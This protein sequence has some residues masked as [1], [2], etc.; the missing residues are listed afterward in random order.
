MGRPKGFGF[1]QYTNFKNAKKA[2]DTMNGQD[3]DGRNIRVNFSS[4]H[5]VVGAPKINFAAS[6]VGALT[7]GNSRDADTLFIGNLGLKT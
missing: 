2:C 5:Q 4:K 3:L 1:V 6:R 7:S